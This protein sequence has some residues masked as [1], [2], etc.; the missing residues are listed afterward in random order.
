[1]AIP[2]HQIDGHLAQR[3]GQLLRLERERRFLTQAAVAARAGMSQ[4][5]ISR[6]ERGTR[7][8]TTAVVQRAFA[9]L[10]QQLV[11]DVEPLDAQV[12]AQIVAGRALTTVERVDTLARYLPVLHRMGDLPYRLDGPLA[13]FLHGVPIRVDGLDVAVAQADIDGVATWLASLP[14]LRRWVDK[15]REFQADR[16]DP[17][18]P[19]PMRWSTPLGEIRV[20]LLAGLP[21]P[22]TI[23]LGSLDHP[24]LPLVDV[25]ATSA[26]VA[27]VVRRAGMAPVGVPDD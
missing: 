18:Y 12:D 5:F 16:T 11:L 13:A 23:R 17:R 27:R 25:L 26:V 7:E 1:M 14:C 6:L 24:V 19:G 21:T 8:P 20:R 4:G 22:V 9:A 10:G 3:I 15:Q 2:D